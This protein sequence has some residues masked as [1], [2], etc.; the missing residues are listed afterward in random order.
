M[1]MTE[2]KYMQFDRINTSK[3]TTLGHWLNIIFTQPPV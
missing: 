3:L 2:F 1:S